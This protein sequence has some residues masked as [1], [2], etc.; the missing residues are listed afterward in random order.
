MVL[1]QNQPIWQ[2]AALTKGERLDK[3]RS[4]DT[5]AYTQEKARINTL[6][7]SY[8]ELGLDTTE[9]EA[10]ARSLDMAATNN[11]GKGGN[12]SA[13]EK[14][15]NDARLGSGEISSYTSIYPSNKALEEK[16]E[17]G[18]QPSGASASI[19]YTS[20]DVYNNVDKS[21]A[22]SKTR[23][24]LDGAYSAR[25]SALEDYYNQLNSKADSEYS[26][27]KQDAFAYAMNRL[28]AIREGLA[29]S[30]LHAEGG[31]SRSEQL[32]YHAGLDRALSVLDAQKAEVISG[33][34]RARE[35]GSA[36]LYS[37]YVKDFTAEQ[38]RL[39]ELYYKISRDESDDSYRKAQLAQQQAQY[40]RDAQSEDAK[41]AAGYT[42]WEKEFALKS[43]AQQYSQTRTAALDQTEK[44]QFDKEYALKLRQADEALSQWEKEFGYKQSQAELS[45]KNTDR[46]YE[47]KNSQLQAQREQ[48]LREYTLKKMAQ[49]QS[50][51]QAQRD[52]ALEL[53]ESSRSYEKWQAEQEQK[54]QSQSS[55]A[56]QSAPKAEKSTAAS[57]QSPA[58][59]EKSPAK[60]QQADTPEARTDSYSA[61]LDTAMWMKSAAAGKGSKRQ[62]TDSQIT[63]WVS[64]LPISTRL[65][66][67]IMKALGLGR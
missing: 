63:D 37:D 31:T 33:N 13:E 46:E 4:G 48:T 12:V 61:F 29:N 25:S 24:L 38:A 51:S 14:A 7:D 45:Q 52:Y 15:Y 47:Y 50:V 62:F 8:K 18:A 23:D 55:A 2:Y 34:N 41:T 28:P 44:E 67:D 56:E 65:R 26:G 42:Q 27:K 9:Q 58:V 19:Q 21:A 17:G 20:Q 11:Y 5:D 39:D 59:E 53:L 3:I 10:W 43:D 32:K 49:D 60:A 35:S 6:I 16:A 66:Q 40:E 54:K 57:A 1:K 22:L 36:G 64:S 30:G